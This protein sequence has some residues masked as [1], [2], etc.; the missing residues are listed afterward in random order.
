M[1]IPNHFHNKTTCTATYTIEHGV[2]ECKPMRFATLEQVA[3]LDFCD[4][5]QRGKSSGCGPVGPPISNKTSAADV[6][7]MNKNLNAYQNT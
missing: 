4:L 7:D 6:G 3:G 5:F 2:T 1:S